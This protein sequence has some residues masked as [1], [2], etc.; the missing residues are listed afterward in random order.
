MK[1]FLPLIAALLLSS[2]A[3]LEDKLEKVEFNYSDTTQTIE[4]IMAVVKSSDFDKN[5]K[6]NGSD[7]AMA[8][9][10]TMARLFEQ[11]E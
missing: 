3:S 2:C 6:I 7:E 4:T 8:L 1:K 10:L 5:G 11:P 9:V